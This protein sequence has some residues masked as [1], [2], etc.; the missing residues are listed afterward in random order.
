MS[1]RNP[2]VCYAEKISDFIGVPFTELNDTSAAFKFVSKYESKYK[3]LY[4]QN[5]LL[6]SAMQCENKIK[7]RFSVDFLE[8]LFSFIDCN[9]G[10]YIFYKSDSVVY[11]GKS[12]DLSSRIFS[13]LQERIKLEPQIDGFLVIKLKSDSDVN[14]AEPYVISKTNPPLNKEFVTDDLPIMFSCETIDRLLE[15]SHPIELFS[16]EFRVKQ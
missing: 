11:V 7:K 3:L 8:V 15:Q 9:R 2:I 5:C 13:S 10:I 14:I 16:N 6:E 4:D 12:F 1:S